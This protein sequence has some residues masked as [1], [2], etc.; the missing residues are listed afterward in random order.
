[1]AH[2]L[3]KGNALGIIAGQPGQLKQGFD[4]DLQDE[5]R[6]IQNIVVAGMGG[7]ALGAEF[8]RSWAGDRLPLPLVITRDYAL[9]AF[10]NAKSL[11]IVSSYSGNT[12][13]ALS[14]LEAAKTSGARIAVMSSGGRLKELALEG[15]YPFLE[16]P[17]GFQ[18]RLAV[19]FGTKAIAV[20]L[21]KLGLLQ[22]VTRE[23]EAAADWITP[24]LSG[25]TLEV[26]T[27]DNQAKQIAM[28]VRGC[29][30]VIYGGPVLAMPARKWK[31][32][33]NENAKNV[34]FWYELPEFN[35]NEFTGW[36][37]P[38]EK[39]LKVIQLHSSL[40]HPQIAKRFEVSNRLLSGHMPDPIIVQA[41]GGTHLQ[42]ML[43]ALLLG[44]FTSAYLAFL[45]GLD[46]TPV[47][48]IE[49]LKKELA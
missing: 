12:E 4:C 11:V 28:A 2:R 38:K 32:D 30:A 20:I 36:L 6:E 48:L 19:L 13:E 46:P 26:P 3:D 33:F 22:G 16:V 47:D 17:G 14:A 29:P 15:G 24:K 8:L 34:A 9:P 31:I 25:W 18:P 35:H 5:K 41:E 40:D 10:V 49:K 23:L 37:N 43:W 44:D 7:S 42:Q 21:E 45:N 1:M 27:A 39:H